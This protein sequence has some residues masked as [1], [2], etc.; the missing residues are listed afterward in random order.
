MAGLLPFAAGTTLA[1]MVHVRPVA[2]QGPA[3]AFSPIELQDN[4]TTDSSLNT[5]KWTVNG[6]EAMAAL[7]YQAS[8]QMTAVTPSIGFS[9][10]QGL[11][12]SGI[13][14]NFTYAGIQ[15]VQSFTP[16]FV[17]ETTVMGSASHGNTFMF[18]LSNAVGSQGIEE[19]AILNSSNPYYGIYANVAVAAGTPWDVIE[20]LD[21]APSLD[22]WYNLTLSVNK[23]GVAVAT[24]AQGST[25]ISSATEYIGLGPY[26]LTLGQVV[27]SPPVN[28]PN[29]A[30]WQYV[31][32][33]A[34]P[35]AP[36]P[37][38]EGL[39]ADPGFVEVGTPMVFYVFVSGGI[40]PLT[41]AYTGLPTGCSSSSV[42]VLNC[43][44]TKVGN[45]TVV[46]TVTDAWD[47]ATHGE[48]RLSVVAPPVAV[49]PATSGVDI[50]IGVGVAGVALGAAGVFVGLVGRR[51]TPGPGTPP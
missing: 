23:S 30:S 50:A 25:E 11:I 24:L 20:H 15:T 19:G 42:T 41:E 27:N 38:L 51:R 18:T 6:P 22:T 1:P 29:S 35:S 43:T 2:A 33:S 17:A 9:S 7:A 46:V 34:L 44:P 31:T 8:S 16:P 36:A 47:R 5:S 26:Y 48:A 4:F 37:A 39:V 14:T 28:G 40:P 45:Y 49:S 3:P 13:T 21:S 32:V 12:L 10:S